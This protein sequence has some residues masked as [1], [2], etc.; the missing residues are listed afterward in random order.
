GEVS[1]MISGQ[2][3]ANIATNGRNIYLLTTLLPGVSNAMSGDFQLQTPVSSDA[4]VSF[5]GGRPGHAMFM[6][7]GGEAYDRGGEGRLSVMPSLESIAEFRALT[8]NYDPE[9]GLSSSG[10]VTMVIKSGTQAFHAAAWEFVRND[11]LGAS[12][13]FTNAAAQQKP[14]LRFNE[15]G[16]NV[17]GPVTF[18]KLYNKDKNKTFFFYNMEW[19]KYVL[20]N[21]VINQTVPLTN[22]YGGNMS[23]GPALHVPCSNQLAPNIA[24]KLTGAGLTLSTPDPATG[25]CSG[26]NAILQPFPN[27]TIPSSVLD[28]NAQLLLKQGIFPAP[29]SGTQ[30]IKGVTAPTNLKDETFRIDHHFTD[31]L[32]LFGHGIIEQINQGYTTSM[33]S[34]DNV[35]T[36]GNTF[37]N[38]TY[39]SVAHMIYTISPTLL[40]ETTFNYNGNRITITPT[41][42]FAQPSGLSI[43]RLFSGPNALNRNPQINLQGSTGASYQS[44]SWPWSNNANSYQWRDDV[45]W[46]KGSHQ[47]KV[48][49]DIMW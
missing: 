17:G 24:S 21:G 7:D 10:T 36:I 30:Y 49:G 15:F 5:D 41:G 16:F 34:G 23:G 26:P 19:R 35:P 9:Y 1:G 32:T 25:N 4:K 42:T 46:S 38:P 13:Y 47:F 11:W 45:S 2:Q 48:G 18:G 12:N 43:Q 22:W 39:S 40:N 44:A 37:K 28:P 14:E 3:V 29:T 8:S 20:G 27:N 33:W 31:K 6:I